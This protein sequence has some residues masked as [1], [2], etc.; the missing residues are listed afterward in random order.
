VQHLAL[1]V[2]DVKI[3]DCQHAPA[4]YSLRMILSGNRTPLSGIM[5]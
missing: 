1:A 4:P 5:R 3:R 2:R